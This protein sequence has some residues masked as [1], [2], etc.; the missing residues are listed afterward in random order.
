MTS[1]F[2]LIIEY[3]GSRFCGWQR[4]KKD[5]TVQGE[6]EKA[7]LT[8]TGQQVVLNGSGR[9][10]AGVHALGQVANFHCDTRLT[11]DI[12]L[13]GLNSLLAE[14]VV[15]KECRQVPDAFH[16]RFDVKSKRY[17]YRILNRPIPGALLRQYVWFVRKKL[18]T[19]AMR[20]AIGH[21]VGRHDF[22]AFEGSG[23]P[24]SS[25][26]RTVM[27]AGLAE[28]QSDYLDIEVEAE[29]FLRYM[30]RNIVG[31]LVDVGLAKMTPGDFKA[32]LQSRSRDRAGITAPPQGLC[33]I[34]VRYEEAPAG[35]ASLPGPDIMDAQAAP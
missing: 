15:I 13:K 9:T 32:V 29:G 18:D 16:A 28:P 33:L 31:T 4:Q 34:E 6:I 30:V 10:D 22:K 8:M 2:K 35:P 14:D 5:R 3:D 26:V 1:N 20:T 17:R 19:G 7:L 24:R 12:L 11:A 27:A 25:T 21:I 23:S